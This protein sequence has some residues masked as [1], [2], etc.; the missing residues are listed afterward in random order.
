M[1]NHFIRRAEARTHHG[2]TGVTRV[3]LHMS[4]SL[5][6]NVCSFVEK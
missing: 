2:G 4:V 5:V 6:F 3:S 1:S